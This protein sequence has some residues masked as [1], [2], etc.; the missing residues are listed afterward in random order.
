[1]RVEPDTVIG[2]RRADLV[3]FGNDLD[4]DVA[5]LGVADCVAESLLC[6]AKDLALLRGVQR[7]FAAVV[8]V[9]LDV[10]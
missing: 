2:D 7:S 9:Y 8:E 1:M 6:D 4:H 3:V 5:G 10:V